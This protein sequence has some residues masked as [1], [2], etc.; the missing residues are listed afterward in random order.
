[1]KHIDSTVDR[2]YSRT[3]LLERLGGVT[4]GITQDVLCI[5]YEIDRYM[6]NLDGLS[7]LSEYGLEYPDDDVDLLPDCVSSIEDSDSV[8]EIRVG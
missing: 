8:S 1:M 6:K 7:E 5:A 2:G 4:W 3:K